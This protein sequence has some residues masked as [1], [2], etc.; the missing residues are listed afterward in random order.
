MAVKG[1]PLATEP[2]RNL[3]AIAWHRTQKR[4][5]QQ[6]FSPPVA[7]LEAEESEEDESALMASGRG[8][9]PP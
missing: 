1:G 8:G 6:S 9:C 3:L 5:T 7:P 4:A 2:K